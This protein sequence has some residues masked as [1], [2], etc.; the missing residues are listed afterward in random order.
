[1]LYLTSSRIFRKWLVI[2]YIFSFNI[3][4]LVYER[5]GEL[6]K[7]KESHFIITIIVIFDNI[8]LIVLFFD[9]KLFFKFIN[10]YSVIYKAGTIDD[11]EKI[12]LILLVQIFEFFWRI[13]WQKKSTSEW[14]TISA[15]IIFQWENDIIHH[16][17]LIKSFRWKHMI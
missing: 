1:M 8:V 15:M 9:F 11:L 3:F 2:L 16:L 17:H 4:N 12:I 7:R 5:K 14:S 6:M 10:F 13:N